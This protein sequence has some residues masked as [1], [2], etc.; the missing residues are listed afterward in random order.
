MPFIFGA[1]WIQE[2]LPPIGMAFSMVEA[3]TILY[4]LWLV[5]GWEA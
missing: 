2:G 1:A 5:F 4:I 3:M